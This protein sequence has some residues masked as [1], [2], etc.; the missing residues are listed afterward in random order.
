M[1]DLRVFLSHTSDLDAR[2]DQATSFVETAIRTIA[3]LPGF[4][5]E[6]Q[7]TTF[8]AEDQTSAQVV[9]RRLARCDIYV[10]IVGYAHGTTVEADPAGRSFVELEF[11]VAHEEVGLPRIVLMLDADV[12]GSACIA[13]AQSAFRSR[14]E[15]TQELV[16]ARFNDPGELR[17][18]LERALEAFRPATSEHVSCHVEWAAP[19]ELSSIGVDPHERRWAV[20]VRN[21]G[22]Y[23][24]FN[25]IAT[26]H[27]NNGGDDFPV[28]MGT[29]AARDVMSTPYILNLECESFDPD[30]DRPAVDL[31]FTMAGVQWHRRPDGSLVPGRRR[32]TPPV[33]RPR[34]RG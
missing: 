6:E 3:A 19:G 27:S 16:F 33:R 22:D 26:V 30:G 28:D 14:L 4:S 7:R 17:Q 23:P 34:K 10:G 15:A 32:S 1:E 25:V 31:S 5:V 2:S 29:L 13:P 9:R 21:A 11:D 24:A 20:Y 12:A 18:A 8:T